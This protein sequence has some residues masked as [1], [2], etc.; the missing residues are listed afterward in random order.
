MLEILYVD[1]D[2][3]QSY[4]EQSGRRSRLVPTYS[5]GIGLSG[6]SAGVSLTRPELSKVHEQI[7]AVREYLT[8]QKLLSHQRPTEEARWDIEEP[9]LDQPPETRDDRHALFREETVEL[10][11]IYIPPHEDEP[12]L[13]A[14]LSLWISD[15][16][17]VHRLEPGLLLLIGNFPLPDTP[18]TEVISG[19]SLLSMLSDALSPEG[20]RVRPPNIPGIGAD[21]RQALKMFGARIGPPKLA[22]ALYRVRAT[23]NETE[24]NYSIT[25][26]GYPIA[27][28]RA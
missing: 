24:R 18:A 21:T 17:E 5:G 4:A 15:Q 22:T 6:P 16:P 20:E 19:Y 26:V 23:F 2:R 25:T 1:R 11:S 27:I 9:D 12:L 3:L 8:R 10:Q 14:G 7:E 13:K 28:W